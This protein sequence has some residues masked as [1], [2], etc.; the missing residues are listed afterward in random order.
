MRWWKVSTWWSCFPKGLDMI[1]SSLPIFSGIHVAQSS[2][3]CSVF[4]YRCWFLCHF[5]GHCIF[6]PSIYSFWL[7]LWFLQICLS[8]WRLSWYIQTFLSWWQLSRYIQTFLSWWRPSSIDTLLFVLPINFQIIYFSSLLTMNRRYEDILSILFSPFGF[9]APKTLN[10]LAFPSFDFERTWWRLFQKRV[11][12]TK[13][14]IYVFQK[15]S[16]AF[17]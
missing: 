2:F 3:L 15:A 5:F 16:C 13:F 8:W 7:L 4:E 9:I 14:D 10:Y 11:V 17:N 1:L 6:C 12:R